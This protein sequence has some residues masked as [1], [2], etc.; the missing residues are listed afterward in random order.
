MVKAVRPDYTRYRSTH[1]QCAGS[2]SQCNRH[3]HRHQRQQDRALRKAQSNCGDKR[4][5]QN[6][7]KKTVSRYPL[8][9]FG[10]AHS[11]SRAPICRTRAQLPT[12]HPKFA[13]PGCRPGQFN[14]AMARKFSRPVSADVSRIT[15]STPPYTESSQSTGLSSALCSVFPLQQH[16][17]YDF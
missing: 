4:C 3:Q 12:R 11:L 1:P 14:C 16:C 15:N 17:W 13:V 8:L 2:S 9:H 10:R 6:I 5:L 7:Q